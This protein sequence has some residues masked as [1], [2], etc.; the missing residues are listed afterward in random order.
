[1]V[2]LI[3]NNGY[4]TIAI[5]TPFIRANEKGSLALDCAR[6]DKSGTVL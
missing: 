3:N 5:T 6:G 2:Q 1:M 4:L